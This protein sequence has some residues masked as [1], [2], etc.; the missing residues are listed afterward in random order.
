MEINIITLGCSKNL[1]DSEKLLGQ[2]TKN[3][4][5]VYHNS[6]LPAE[7]TIIN[8]C[9]FI[10]DAKTESIDTIFNWVR[11]KEEGKIKKLFV[12][13]CL[14]ERYRESLKKDIPEI[15]SFFG[16][17]DQMSILTALQGEY[18]SGEKESR[19]ITTPAHYAYLKISEGCNRNCAFCAIPDI[20]GNQISIPIEELIV[21]AEFL[22]SKGVKELILIAQDPSSYGTDLYK[23]KAFPELLEKL[24]NIADFEWIRLHYFH[25]VGF[26]AKEIIDLMKKYPKICKY[27]DIPIQHADNNILKLMNR[28]HEISLINNILHSFRSEIPD[29]CIRTT[30]I[31]GFPGEGKKEFDALKDYVQMAEFDKLGTF[32]YS[33]EEDTL[34]AKNFKDIVSQGLK[35]KR[36]KEIMDLQASISLKK[37]LAKIGQVFKVVIDK[38]EGEYYIGRTEFDSPE[39]DNEVLIP[40]KGNS[41]KVGNF[42]KVEITDALEHDIFGRIVQ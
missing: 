34:A 4:H 35:K 39:V 27:L 26:P 22:A 18:F 12:M 21:E 5:T 41:L 30:V 28:G 20:R 37:N 13:G 16:V 42:H 1:V 3:G 2:L 36:M 11:A 19:L 24:A 15:D 25:P 9:G 38:I 40:L 31:T 33:H 17:W 32:A 23:Q 8:T 10:L 14:S 7:C 29:I 6:E